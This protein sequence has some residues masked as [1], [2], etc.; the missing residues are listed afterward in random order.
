M[1]SISMFRAV[2]FNYQYRLNP[3][4]IIVSSVPTANLGGDKGNKVII[5]DSL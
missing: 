5:I 3:F 4:M 2:T 1:K